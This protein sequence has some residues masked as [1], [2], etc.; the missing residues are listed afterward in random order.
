MFR[1]YLK[2]AVR[3]LL[4]RKAFT[5]I[6]IL[7]LA[8]GMAVCLLIV[9][10]IRSELSY[11]N[12]HENG[13]RV[14]RVVL[15]RKYP[16]RMTPYSIIPVSI[17][18]AMQKEFPEVALCTGLQNFAGNN[19]VFLKVGDQL[20]EEPHILIADSN[21]F[22]VFTTP[23]MEGDTAEALSKPNMAVINETT[24]KKMFGSVSKAMGQYFET[25]AKQR[26]TIS[27]VCKDWPENSH[28]QFNVLLSFGSFPFARQTNYTGFS[29]WTYLLLKPGANPVA[30]ETK[31]P[32]IIQKYVSGDIARNFGMSYEAFVAAGNGYHYFLQPL[33]K[34]HLIS[35]MEAEAKP[36]GSMRAVYIFGIVA[37][38]ILGIACIN[39]INL[40]T[41]RSMERAKEVGIRKTFGSEKQSLIFQFLMESVL[42]S[43]LSIVLALGLIWLL[44]PL[45]NRMSGKDLS[46]MSFFNPLTLLGLL[47]FGMVVGMLAGLYPAFVLSSFAP[48]KV[49]KGKFK[50]SRYGTMLRNGLVIFQFAISI[51]LIICTIIV[52]QQMQYMLGDKLGFRKDH[53]IEIQRGDLLNGKARAFRNELLGIAGVENVTGTTSMPGDQG[54]FGVTWQPI[55]SKE[56]MTGRGIIVDDRFAK[57]L[58]LEMKEG[59]FFSRDFPTD[60]LGVVLNEKAVSALG[61]KGPIIGARL[62]TTAPNLN[63]G[64]VDSPYIYTVVGVVKDFHF[65]TLHQAIA[66]LIFTSSA[67]FQDFAPTVTVRIKGDNFSGTVKSVE[68]VWHNFVPEKP[69]HYTFLDQNLAAQY[70]AEQTIQRVFTVF[71][72]LAIFIACIGLLGLAAYA[73]QQRIREISIRK[74]LGASAGNIIG[75]LS[76]DF[77]K[78]VTISAVVAFPL[79]W[80]GMHSWLQGFAYRVGLSWWIFALAW[81]LSLGITMLTISFQ[82]IRAARANPVKTLRSE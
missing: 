69:F 56:S 25:D 71:S 63:P 5:L 74:V 4:K 65:Q 61:L 68:R 42:V 47:V 77:I 12:F 8:T 26:F 34:I 13:D 48:I 81:I 33:Q 52:N 55:G 46:A 50:S 6:N 37:I 24:A 9:L 79:A 15:E 17:G 29:T 75:M 43:L 40:S 44:L 18:P 60:S 78:L 36:N 82:A 70:R 39:F 30:L 58:G 41:A 64:P 16:E 28:Q 7:G 10:F 45:F 32:S 54:F 72:A 22:R 67:R 11:D 21:F 38:F 20:F 62:T 19:N 23:L 1:N 80:M 76:K 53:V 73:T 51:I 66:P 57:T 27:G 2:V 14:Y 31:F 35:D 3:S 49:L 59:R